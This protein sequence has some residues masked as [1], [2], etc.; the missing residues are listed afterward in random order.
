MYVSMEY[1]RI[2]CPHC[3]K[4][5]FKI[6]PGKPFV[7]PTCECQDPKVEVKDARLRKNTTSV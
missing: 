4:E 3:K 2:L 6:F 1:A 7:L 5:I